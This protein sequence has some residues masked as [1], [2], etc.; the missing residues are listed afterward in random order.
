VQERKAVAPADR[1]F[2]YALNALRLNDG[3]APGDFEQRTGLGAAA[4][5]PALARAAS[6]GWIERDAAG[7]RASARGRALLN[8]LTALFL[9]P[10]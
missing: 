4:L 9:P 5:E 10:S 1:P 8:R 7:I 6:Q 3:F 2:E